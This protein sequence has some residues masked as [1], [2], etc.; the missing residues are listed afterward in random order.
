MTGTDRR[1]VPRCQLPDLHRITQMIIRPGREVSLV[2][3]STRG[4]LVESPQPLRP[5]SLV[6]VQMTVCDRRLVVRGCVLRSS[7]WK[8]GATGI[9]YRS[10]IC[11]EHHVS[12]LTRGA[13]PGS[14]YTIGKYVSSTG[15]GQLI[16]AP[17]MDAT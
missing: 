8:L 2:D 12:W 13:D 10:A 4:A 17:C 9:W 11:F 16:P 15:D 7:V 1:E 14:P 6:E 5:D 3:L